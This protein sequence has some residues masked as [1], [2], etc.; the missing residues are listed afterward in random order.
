MGQS[1]TIT[2]IS[3]RASIRVRG[4]AAFASLT[5]PET[6]PD[7]S[8]VDA[9]RGRVTVTVATATPGQTASAEAY[10]GRFIIHQDSAVPYETHLTLSLPLGSCRSVRLPS[11]AHHARMGAASGNR[12]HKSN[13]RQ[14]WVS[15]HGGGWGTGGRYVSTSV[16]GTSWLTAD[17]CRASRVKV[18]EGVV[19]VHDLIHDTTASVSAGHEYIAAAPPEERPGYVPPLGEVLTGESGGDPFAFGH[20]VGK[21]VSLFG[22]FGHWG[23]EVSSLLGYV[24]SFHARLFLHLSTDIGYGGGAGQEISPAAISI[25]RSDSYLVRLCEELAGSPA[26]VYIALLPEMNQANNAYSAFN[27]N[28][29]SRGASNSTAAFRQAFRRTVLILRGGS[30]AVVNR[31]L[32]TLKL[33]PLRTTLTSLPKPEVSFMWAPQTAGTPDTPAN[34]PA[35]YYPGGA[36]VDIVGTDFYSAFP[37]FSGLNAL[38]SAYSN[39]PFGFNEWAMWQ[40]GDPAFVRQL[41]AFVGSHRRTALMV[42]NEGLSSDGPF[43]LKKFRAATSEIRRQLSS[44][45]FLEYPPE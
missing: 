24:Q 44:S 27:P 20:Q 9:T 39:K 19:Q 32:R 5:S 1:E 6:V 31:R 43:R 28:G 36:Y 40:S 3:G 42:Y 26:P 12:R 41:F 17:S 35:A 7:E 10:A 15:E 14:L 38:Y 33:P 2:L 22:Y 13:S 45:R 18:T 16:E 29:S 23:A 21:H 34:S 25:G 30:V 4:S 11:R 37:N 8:E